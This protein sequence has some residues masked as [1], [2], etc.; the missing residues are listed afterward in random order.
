MA[1][2]LDVPGTELKETFGQLARAGMPFNP[3]TGLNITGAN[4]ERLQKSMKSFGWTDPRFVTFEQA[5]A[6]GWLV[7]PEAESVGVR[8][9]DDTNGLVEDYA[10]LNAE[11]IQ[12]MPSMETMLAMTDSE[13]ERMRDAMARAGQGAPALPREMVR[14]TGELGEAE[15]DALDAA[16]RARHAVIEDNYRGMSPVPRH[17]LPQDI[18]EV[19]VGEDVAALR[20]I[21]N[22]QAREEAALTLGMNAVDQHIVAE[23]TRAVEKMRPD[24]DMPEPEVEV[25]GESKEGAGVRGPAKVAPVLKDDFAKAIEAEQA[26][27]RFAV[28]APYW[29]NGL[30]NAEGLALA[31]A[32][33]KT[34]RD[35]KLAEHKDAI[36]KLFSLHPKARGLGLDVV[37][38]GQYLNNEELKRNEAEPSGLLA[39]ALLRDKSGCYRPNGGGVAVLQDRGDSVVLKDRSEQCY[40]GA[41]EL[42]AAKGWKSIEIKGKPAEMAAVWLEAKLMGLE[43]VNYSPTE[44]DAEKFAQ[45][46]AELSKHK[47]GMEQ[48]SERVEI[49]PF[50]NEKGE[51]K[52]ASVT[53]TVSYP[54]SDPATFSSPKDAAKAVLGLSPS[55][56]PVVVRSVT[57]A[58]GRVDEDVLAGFTQSPGQEG[59]LQTANEVV[60]AEFE[61]AMDEVVAESKMANGVDADRVQAG[62]DGLYSGQILAIEGNMVAQKTGRDPNVVV[63][64][65]ISKINGKF[66]RVGDV[67]DIRYKN[68]LGKIAEKDRGKDVER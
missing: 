59:A 54:G 45:R 21:V 27:L 64:H 32:L 41:M 9:R 31:D 34:I 33:N 12:G 7:K 36:V 40:R 1:L 4:V 44:K 52:T 15:M 42:A 57:R 61:Q 8:V 23:V 29:K 13:M 63:W 11:N 49:K 20:G 38:E 48:T 65:D 2:N 46:L 37:D 26:P 28:M 58:D 18:A 39:G 30:H 5:Q 10:L 53:Y 66:P 19:I 6:N 22:V 51:M 68:G 16:D 25:E 24:V 43:V 60:D 47:K 3:V 35:Q 14:E 50:V 67:I 56:R 55:I 62:S 17:E